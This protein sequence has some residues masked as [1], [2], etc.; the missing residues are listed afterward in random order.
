LYE[1]RYD[2]AAQT[3]ERALAICQHLYGNAHPTVAELVNELGSVAVKQERFDDAER[4]FQRMIGTYEAIYHDRNH[5]QVA[6]GMANLASV[7]M[8]R[9]QW[10]R[11]EPLLRE[12][13][14]ICI[15]TQGPDHINTGIAHVKLGRTLLRQERYQEAEA[16][17]LAGYRILIKQSN[18]TDSFLRAA[19]KDLREAY[20]ALNEPEKAKEY[21]EPAPQQH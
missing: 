5:Y 17:T 8:N 19:R 18:P 4:L 3:L 10:A 14:R 20:T 13:L 21:P 7:Y 9:K 11:A 16:Q 2:E 12:A 6:V 15:A 1:D